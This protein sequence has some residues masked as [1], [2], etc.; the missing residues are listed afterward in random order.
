MFPAERW[1]ADHLHPY[2]FFRELPYAVPPLLGGS[3]RNASAAE[4]RATDHH[5]DEVGDI[6]KVA[7]AKSQC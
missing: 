6:A 2:L 3:R 1:S 5:L 4:R 7:S